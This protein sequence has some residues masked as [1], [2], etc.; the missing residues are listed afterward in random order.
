MTI[1]RK[2]I[3]DEDLQGFKYFKVLSGLLETLGDAGCARDIAGNRIVHR[4]N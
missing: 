1:R 3:K 2:K 4:V